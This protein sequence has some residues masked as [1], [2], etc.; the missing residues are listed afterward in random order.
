[1]SIGSLLFSAKGRIARKSFWIGYGPMLVVTL[2]L[3]AYARADMDNRMVSSL[4]LLISLILLYPMICIFAKRLH[5]IGL[6]GWLQLLYWAVGVGFAIF[7]LSRSF[8][9][10]MSAALANQGDQ[11]AAT[12]AVKEAVTNAM[13]TDPVMR[14]SPYVTYVI[15]GLWTLWLGLAP[16]NSGDNKYGPPEGS[17]VI[18]TSVV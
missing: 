4:T 17:A 14:Y 15:S 2:A 11:A 12:A 6:S 10:S 18:Q 5:D 9:A 16:G 8:G 3:G 7:V 1:M 13:Q